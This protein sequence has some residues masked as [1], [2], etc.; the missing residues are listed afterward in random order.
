MQ[1]CECRLGPVLS[2]FDWSIMRMVYLCNIIWMAC[3]CIYIYMCGVFVMFLSIV[4]VV[5][6]IDDDRVS[7]RFAIV[8]AQGN[9]VTIGFSHWICILGFAFPFRRYTA[10]RHL[11]RARSLPLL[12]LIHFTSTVCSLIFVFVLLYWVRPSNRGCHSL[13]LAHFSD[14]CVRERVH[15]IVAAAATTIIEK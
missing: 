13:T 1:S 5:L 12:Q 4:L 2:G 10:K 15:S 14:A 11:W 6:V 9:R 8:K 3:V 7:M